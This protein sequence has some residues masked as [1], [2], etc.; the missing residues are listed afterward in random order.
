LSGPLNGLRVVD[1]SRGTAGPRMTGMLADYGAEVIWVEPPGGDPWRRALQVPYSV[2]NRNKR[3]VELDLRQPLGHEALVEL[4]RAGDLFVQSWRPGVAERLGLGY[5]EMHEELPQL[6]YCSISGFGTKGPHRDLPGYDALVH[7]VVGLMGAQSGYRAGPIFVGLPLASAGAAYLALIG[8]LAALYR[9]ESDGWGRHVETS[10]VDGVLAYLSQAWGYSE[11]PQGA[12]IGSSR[13]LARPGGAAGYE[14]AD[15][16]YLGVSTFGRGAF[17]RLMTVLGIDDRIPPADANVDASAPLTPEEL[18]AMR[19]EIPRVFASGSRKVWIERLLE[20]DVAAIP[21]LHQGEVFDEPQTVHNQMV[22]EVEDPTLG[23]IEQVAPP[24]RFARTPG[25]I[26]RPAPKIGQHTAEVF[27]GLRAGELQHTERR[28]SRTRDDRPLLDGV[29][30]LD[31]GHWYAGP[32][33]ARLLADL[34]ADVIKVEPPSGDGMRGFERAFSAAQ[35]GK[36]AIAVDLKDPELERLRHALIERADIVQHNLRTGVAERLG[37]GYEQ[38]RSQRPEVIYLHAPGWGTSGPDV[39]RQAF[40][41]LMSGYVGA[42]YEVAGRGNPPLG[43][44]ANEDSGA[45]MLGAVSLLM[46][47]WQREHSGQGQYLE[48]PQL[49]ST[50]SD[51]KHVIRRPDGTLMG[52]GSLDAEQLG[53]DPLHR[54]YQTSDGWICLVA[55]SDAHVAALGQVLGPGLHGAKPS[56]TP[57]AR[58]A[59]DADLGALLA[60]RISTWEAG[61]LLAALQAAGVPVAVPTVDNNVRFM[62]DPMNLRLGRVGEF[63]HPRLGKVREPGVMMR[64]DGTQMP[65]HRRAPELGEHTE[66]ILIWAGYDGEEISGL[67]SRGSIQ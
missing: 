26:E 30:V 33:S 7:A 22:V 17:D 54:L 25:V 21:V 52:A 56:L 41:P 12:V 38:V 60:Q 48:L 37:V 47:L 8:S 44:V 45:G 29:T 2:F 28:P 49:N 53:T 57:E 19:T 46:A 35:A 55:T 20:A 16:E 5:G 14:C 62:D 9:R 67:R 18:E 50:M 59:H 39:H 1:C 31:L 43:P 63:V 15:G 3:S 65:E 10:L 24:T 23:R 58:L 34:G 4:C 6:V 13:F 32:Y 64:I 27:A 36:R 42:S 11:T 66:E 40:A 61:D 51:M